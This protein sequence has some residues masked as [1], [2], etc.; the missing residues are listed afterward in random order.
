MLVL[1][2]ISGA[3]HSNARQRKKKASLP[4]LPEIQSKEKRK[5]LKISRKSRYDMIST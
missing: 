3:E 1:A 4:H 2:L 5:R